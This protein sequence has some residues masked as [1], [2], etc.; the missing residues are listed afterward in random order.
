M[1]NNGNAR[2]DL[3]V[4]VVKEPNPEANLQAHSLKR[5]PV[6]Y[7]DQKA[8]PDEQWHYDCEAVFVFRG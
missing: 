4:Y 7:P 2:R 3:A 8:F 6:A 5:I 1:G